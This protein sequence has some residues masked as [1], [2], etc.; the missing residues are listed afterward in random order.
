MSDL[1]LYAF[2]NRLNLLYFVPPLPP[3][4]RI[5]HLPHYMSIKLQGNW[6]SSTIE[7]HSVIII[8]IN[9][10]LLLLLLLLLPVAFP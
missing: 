8:I 4:H 10:L 1:L 5:P 3:P 7:E 6:G 9:I 2:T